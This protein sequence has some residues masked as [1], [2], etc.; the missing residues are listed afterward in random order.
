MSLETNKI[1]TTGNYQFAENESYLLI[2][3]YMYM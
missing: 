1:Q 3:S 2:W